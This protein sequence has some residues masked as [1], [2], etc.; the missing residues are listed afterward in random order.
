[1][2]PTDAKRIEQREE[3]L[4]TRD[5]VARVPGVEQPFEADRHCGCGGAWS[6]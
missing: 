4:L 5:C 3:Q 6:F 2:P 1:M